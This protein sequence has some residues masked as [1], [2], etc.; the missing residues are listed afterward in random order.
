MSDDQY[1]HLVKILLIGESGVGKTCIL[2]RFNRDEFL[3][4][5]L[6][7]IAIDFKMKIFDVDK[8]R[9]KM[10]I[11]DTAGQERYNTLTS[12]FF[13]AAH[14]IMVCYSVTD[15]KSF[16]SINKWIA[17][18]KNLAPKDVKVLLVGNKS[19]LKNDRVVSYEAGKECADRYEVFFMETS[20]FSGDNVINA[21]ESLGRMI[22]KDIKD[23]GNGVKLVN[24]GKKKKCC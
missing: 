24:Q 19:D 14:G 18:I 8:S 22:L 13:K 3:V 11:W 17:Q 21:F 9:L 4:N 5:H 20:A 12:G 7:T 16:Q 6:A 10:Q 2:Q 15:E 1:D 23:E